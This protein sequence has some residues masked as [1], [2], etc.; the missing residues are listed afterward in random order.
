[1]SDTIK[2]V[3]I[4]G[5]G[6]NLGPVVLE[7][8][9]SD[10]H[11][12]VSILS[13]KSSKSTFP[14]DIKVHT[15][16]DDYPEAQLLEAFKGQDAVVSLIA[17]FHVKQEIA[18]ID[19]AIKAGVKRFLPSEFGGN[20]DNPK[21]REALPFFSAKFEVTEHLRKQESK[22]MTW[23]GIVTG[24]FFDWGLKTGFLGFDLSSQK[25]TIYDDGK[26]RFGTTNVATIGLAVARTLHK[27]KETTNR[28]VY[29]AST[30]TSQSEVLVSLEKATGKKW[31]VS[32]ASIAAKVQEGKD[33]VA[34]GDMSG[35][36]VWL[37]AAI[38]S[39][40]SGA[41]Y[42]SD[43][44]LDNKLLELPAE[45]LDDMISSVVKG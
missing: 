3:I 21:M 13:R 5:A 45:N 16:D 36:F 15:I 22:G 35:Y 39:N 43:E 1:M 38:H 23:S 32:H 2:N 9:T 34:K 4:L 12:T 28:H 40:G 29:I 20:M 27:L 17:G 24:P 10:G 44:P 14:S 25:A 26:G 42:A 6:G 18:I 30:T 7:A 31:D 11:F 8:L 37:Q 33:S 19:A 41:D